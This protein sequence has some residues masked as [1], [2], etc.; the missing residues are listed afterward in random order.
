[1]TKKKPSLIS[2][3]LFAI[4]ALLIIYV[5]AA[6]VSAHTYISGVI[7][8]GQASLKENFFD[9]LG[10][11]MQAGA[12]YFLFAVLFVVIGLK[13]FKTVEIAP[14][15][16]ALSADGEG[17]EEDDADAEGTEDADG[18]DEDD[19][20]AETADPADIEFDEIAEASDETEAAEDQEED[21]TEE[22]E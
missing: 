6:L 3:V 2:I 18:Q 1:M 16:F 14:T 8:A 5:V 4:S 15:V 21:K 12:E 17:T 20:N 10:V 7:D 9:I 11:Y 22:E 13:S 19:S